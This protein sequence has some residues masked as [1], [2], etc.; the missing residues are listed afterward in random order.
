MITVVATLWLFSVDP[1][2]RTAKPPGQ[3][4]AGDQLFTRWAA[5]Y[6]KYDLYTKTPIRL[7]YIKGLSKR[8][9]KA[10]GRAEIN[11]KTGKVTVNVKGLDALP[12]RY[13]Y[14]VW[15]VDHKPG[16]HNSVALDL[17][18]GGDVIMNLGA[19]PRTGSKAFSISS[20]EFAQFEIDM[21]AVIRISPK[22]EPEFIVG[23]MQSI[24]FKMNR[25]A[26]LMQKENGF[27]WFVT[28][29]E[30]ATGLSGL[31]KKGEKIFFNE[32]F[33]GNGRTC[34]TCHRAENNFIVDPEFIQDLTA[35]ELAKKRFDVNGPK[36][37][38]FVAGIFDPASKT[39]KFANPDL[40]PGLFEDPPRMFFFS[41]ILE[42]LDGFDCVKGFPGSCPPDGDDTNGITVVDPIASIC[43]EEKCEYPDSISVRRTPPT[44]IN[45]QLTLPFGLGG[46]FLN[47][48][49]FDI[50]AVVQHFPITL[51]RI[52]G[53]DFRMPKMDELEAL[54]AFQQS[55]LLPNNVAEMNFDP[56]LFAVSPAEQNGAALFQGAGRCDA[57]HIGPTLDNSVN[58]DTGVNALAFSQALPFDNGGEEE[59]GAVCGSVAVPGRPMG[60]DGGSFNVPALIGVK[61]TAPFFHNGAVEMLRDAVAFYISREFVSSTG[62]QFVAATGGGDC[63][64]PPGHR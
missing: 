28:K 53:E 12:E 10:L 41:H 64:E 29:A 17:G 39:V 40:P 4:L 21:A 23:G 27:D 8:F 55:L 13:E 26:R 52:E 2:V 3:N 61:D 7:G 6:A 49:I 43:N 42:N 32:T 5:G 57:C 60:C 20:K 56:F 15:L 63:P 62:G 24:F 47:L 54:E 48:L 30:A 11:F 58:F 34:G 35:Q 46:D 22:R 51:N 59:D 1:Q 50:G 31:I 37:P 33:D 14:Q 44:V 16:E 9:T 36:D 38:L 45:I 25:Q 18:E 19:L